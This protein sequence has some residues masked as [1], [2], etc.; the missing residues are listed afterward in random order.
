MPKED[1]VRWNLGV[2]TALMRTKFGKAFDA[3]RPDDSFA[4]SHDERWQAQITRRS[5][6]E[7]A[8][9]AILPPE[10]W[11]LFHIHVGGNAVVAA[12]FLGSQ[13]QILIHRPGSWEHWFGTYD[14]MDS[15]NFPAP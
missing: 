9:S 14:P 15:E 12:R 7:E 8:K 1:R 6:A 13:I 5:T 2:T 3:Y 10:K 4:I 11:D